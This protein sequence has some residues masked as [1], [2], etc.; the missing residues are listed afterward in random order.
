MFEP[1]K[2]ILSKSTPMHLKAKLVA[3]E[4]YHQKIDGLTQLKKLSTNQ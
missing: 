1:E 2:A 3:L 4:S